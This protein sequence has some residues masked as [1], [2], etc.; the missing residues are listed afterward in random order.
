MMMSWGHIL[1]E[2]IDLAL[3][4]LSFVTILS[5]R[6]QTFSETDHFILFD[7]WEKIQI[8]CKLIGTIFIHHDFVHVYTGIKFQWSLITGDG[9]L[10]QLLIV[11]SQGNSESPKSCQIITLSISLESAMDNVK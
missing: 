2:N 9:I 7:V 3:I 8:F 11:S 1:L 6:T 10:K 5:R 4:C